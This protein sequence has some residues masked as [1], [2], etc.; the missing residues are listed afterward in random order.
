MFDKTKIKIDDF[1]RRCILVVFIQVVDNNLLP[2]Y[3]RSIAFDILPKFEIGYGRE[4]EQYS[5]K[6]KYHEGWALWKICD[7]II[8]TASVED[9][10]HHACLRLEIQL[11]GF[12]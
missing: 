4:K 1:D 2:N 3:I 11:K 12:R 9:P 10:E 8:Q 7:Y 6:F 5:L